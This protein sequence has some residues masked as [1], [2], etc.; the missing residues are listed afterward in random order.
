MLSRY[1]ENSSPFALDLVGAVLRQG[2][3]VQKM[4]DIDWLHSPALKFTMGRLLTKFERFFDIL[5]C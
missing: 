5:L 2:V 3:F 4:H 1:W